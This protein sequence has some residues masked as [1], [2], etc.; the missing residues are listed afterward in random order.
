MGGSSH[1]CS[2]GGDSMS[3]SSVS[4]MRGSTTVGFPSAPLSS[5]MGGSSSITENPSL[6]AFTARLSES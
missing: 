2:G 5:T 3:H 1:V 4:S 6:R